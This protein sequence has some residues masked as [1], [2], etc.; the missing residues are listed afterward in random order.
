MKSKYV[1]LKLLKNDGAVFV[2]KLVELIKLRHMEL[3]P[4]KN[5][6]THSALRVHQQSESVRVPN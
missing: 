6:E 3:K 4:L 1:Q 2:Y 5:N